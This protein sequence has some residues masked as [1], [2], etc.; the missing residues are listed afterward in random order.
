T[1]QIRNPSRNVVATANE[2]DVVKARATKKF[3]GTATVSSPALWSPES[4]DLYTLVTTVERDGQVVDR[5]ETEFGIR[6]FAFDPD[7]GFFLNGKPYVIKGTCNHQD[8]AGVG[9]ALPDR[10]QYFRVERLKEFGCNA[11]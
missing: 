3:D 8:H 6:T 2:S 10:L 1:W 7:K 9:S 5:V 4:P 11:I